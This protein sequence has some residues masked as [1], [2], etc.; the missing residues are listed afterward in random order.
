MLWLSP[1]RVLLGG[2][3][4]RDVRLVAVEMQAARV[5]ESWSDL[6]PH[7]VF[8]DVPERR[9]VVR[10]ERTP[11]SGESAPARPGDAAGLSFRAASSSGGGGGEAVSASVVVRSVALRLDAARGPT[12]VIECVAVSADGAGDP[13]VVAPGSGEGGA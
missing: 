7:A 8:A 4:L 10:V 11:S 3:E 12:Q 13:L 5:V 2:V 1:T 6:G 9:T